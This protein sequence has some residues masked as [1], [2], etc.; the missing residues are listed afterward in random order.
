[1]PKFRLP[2]RFKRK[3][4]VQPQPVFDTSRLAT[5]EDLDKL[6]AEIKSANQTEE[7]KKEIAIYK[8]WMSM[9]QEE[10]KK[11]WDKMPYSQQVRL[12][13]IVKLYKNESEVSQDGKNARKTT[14]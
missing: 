4:K 1:M 12:A 9:K 13:Q 11:L 14:H 8:K 10:K 7:Q 3:P 6:R 2:F 5:K